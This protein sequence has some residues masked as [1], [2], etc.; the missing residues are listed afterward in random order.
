MAETMVAFHMVI[1]FGIQ[2][3]IGSNPRSK[4][5][6]WGLWSYVNTFSVGN[7]IRD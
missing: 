7:K 1:S 6:K 4:E 5:D 2:Y 3:L